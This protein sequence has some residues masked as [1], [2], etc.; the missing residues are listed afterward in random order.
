MLL[1][2]YPNYG[3]ASEFEFKYWVGGYTE[4]PADFD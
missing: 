2:A 4:P 3:T 1:V